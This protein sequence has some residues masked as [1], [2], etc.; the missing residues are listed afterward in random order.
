MNDSKTII[1]SSTYIASIFMQA[2]G[3]LTPNWSVVKGTAG[4]TS[5]KGGMGLWKECVSTD[6]SQ[7]AGSVC[8]KIPKEDVTHALQSVRILSVLAVFMTVAGMVLC[9]GKQHYMATIVTTLAGVLS[10]VA[11][12]VWATN[13]DLHPKGTSLGYSWGVNLTGGLL[14][15]AV[16]PVKKSIKSKSMY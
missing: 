7:G 4:D 1:V 14:A 16:W 12:I 10:V 3:I 5:V 13:K 11:S 9:L 2:I 6:A 15:L 8:V